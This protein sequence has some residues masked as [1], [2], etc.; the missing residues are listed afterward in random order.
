MKMGKMVKTSDGNKIMKG[1]DSF[2]IFRNIPGTPSYWKGFRNEILA[3][4]EQLGPFHMFFTLSC[5]EARWDQVIASV[6]QK[7]IPKTQI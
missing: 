6:L 1:G 7:E 2:S 3:K 4:I 5:A